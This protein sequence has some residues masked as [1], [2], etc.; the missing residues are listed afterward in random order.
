MGGG[1]DK[2][3]GHG[4]GGAHPYDV[5]SVPEAPYGVHPCAA[6]MFPRRPHAWTATPSTQDALSCAQLLT[7]APQS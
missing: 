5:A 3:Q 2:W 1:K 6:D 7:G 4:R